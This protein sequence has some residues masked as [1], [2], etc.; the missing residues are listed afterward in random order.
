MWTKKYSC[1]HRYCDYATCISISCHFHSPFHF[2]EENEE[3]DLAE[4]ER[5]TS[6]RMKYL[7]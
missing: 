2:K 1:F 3:H 7:R 4:S 5:Q 6:H